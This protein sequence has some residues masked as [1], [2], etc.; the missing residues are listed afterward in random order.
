MYGKLAVERGGG[1]GGRGCFIGPQKDGFLKPEPTNTEDI[2]P[3][4]QKQTG[5]AKY[6]KIKI[7]DIWFLK[8]LYIYLSWWLERIC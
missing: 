5:L 8:N 1:G 7:V 6:K 3:E 4:K 2:W